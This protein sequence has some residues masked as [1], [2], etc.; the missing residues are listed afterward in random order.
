VLSGSIPSSSLET[1]GEHNL[2]NIQGQGCLSQRNTEQLYTG[3]QRSSPR[4]KPTTPH[5]TPHPVINPLLFT[6]LF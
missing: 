3:T 4:H 1:L 2:S 6:A 5:T